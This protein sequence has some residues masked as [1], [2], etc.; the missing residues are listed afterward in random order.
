[1]MGIKDTELQII[2]EKIINVAR[3]IDSRLEKLFS[4]SGMRVNV[5]PFHPRFLPVLE[6]SGLR[7]SKTDTS[8]IRAWIYTSRYDNLIVLLLELGLIR[9]IRYRGKGSLPEGSF[10][11]HRLS[12]EKS[13]AQ[14]GGELVGSFITYGKFE[15]TKSY[16]DILIQMISL[17]V[18]NMIRPL[19]RI[20]RDDRAF[21]L[22]SPMSLTSLKFMREDQSVM[23]YL[24]PS[25]M[26]T[27]I[28][29]RKAKSIQRD[30]LGE[31]V[32]CFEAP[33]YVVSCKSF[34][35]GGGIP[36]CMYIGPFTSYTPVVKDLTDHLVGHAENRNTVLTNLLGI[37]VSE[38]NSLCSSN[39]KSGS[40]Y[41]LALDSGIP[42]L[43]EIEAIT[44][45]G[46]PHEVLLHSR[47]LSSRLCLRICVDDRYV[48]LFKNEVDRAL[49]G[50]VRRFK[51]IDEVRKHD[52]MIFRIFKDNILWRDQNYICMP[53]PQFI[54]D[55]KEFVSSIEKTISNRLI[56]PF[57]NSNVQKA[58]QRSPITDLWLLALKETRSIMDS[59]PLGIVV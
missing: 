15:E 23:A 9:S 32:E 40:C 17:A 53:V 8:N 34:Q 7:I 38:R 44:L 54:R 57:V 30:I 48:S 28:D 25:S 59:H 35:Q 22:P 19:T 51:V 56:N 58:M 6:Y 39:D 31:N 3:E 2:I 45:L 49:E 55:G 42:Y 10:I 27:L 52:A 26:I 14:L 13:G 5:I 16:D 50:L 33:A 21:I 20:R 41:L 11:I 24:A 36:R 43:P 4:G 29:Y 12:I 37:W 47:D 18:L 46:K 1:M